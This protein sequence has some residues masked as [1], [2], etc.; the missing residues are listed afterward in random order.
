MKYNLNPKYYDTIICRICK[1]SFFRARKVQ[2]GKNL[3]LGVRP[4]NCI[5][6][7]RKCT[8]EYKN[9]RYKNE[10]KSHAGNK[11]KLHANLNSC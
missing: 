11:H 4:R 1:K 9:V 10:F 6:C 5:N 7:S 3:P 8:R 2:R